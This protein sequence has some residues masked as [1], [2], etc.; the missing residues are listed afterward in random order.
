M[1]LRKYRKPETWLKAR[2]RGNRITSS[3]VPTIMGFGF[4]S[5][6]L[7]E[8]FWLKQGKIP[9]TFNVSQTR[10]D[11][12]HFLE[13]FVAVN[14]SE[15]LEKK[16][17]DPGKFALVTSDDYPWASC[18]PDRFTL[19]PRQ[20]LPVMD[21][22][23]E[24]K[25]VGAFQK[26]TWDEG[27]PNRTLVQ[28]LWHMVVCD[29]DE[30]VGAALLGLDE[31]VTETVELQTFQSTVDDML[32]AC[33]RFHK[34]L[35]ADI[36]PQA[37]Y[38]SKPALKARYPRTDPEKVMI[39]PPDDGWIHASEIYS[40]LKEKKK[41]ISA[42]LKKVTNS[43]GDIEA[44]L[45]QEMGEAEVLELGPFVAKWKQID[46]KPSPASSYRR[47]SIKVQEDE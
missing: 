36:P 17:V 14:V 35:E 4:G 45:Q 31:I 16:V 41:E 46:R 30:G 47:F 38:S 23:L 21:G 11:V 9:S 20:E 28:L 33:W 3:D 32:E 42:E 18:S 12:G 26:H 10:L 6:D 24:I 2:Q 37:R 8:L 34:R 15:K 29:L 44:Q 19:D 1:R 43:M 7:L 22:V 40:S 39:L 25:T 27:I 5:N 13:D